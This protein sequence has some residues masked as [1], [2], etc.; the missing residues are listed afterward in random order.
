MYVCNTYM[1]VSKIFINTNF[2]LLRYLELRYIQEGTKYLDWDVK[3]E[4]YVELDFKLPAI[5]VPIENKNKEISA[6]QRVYLD[7]KTAGKPSKHH[8]KSKGV[9]KENVAVIYKGKPKSKKVVIAEGP[10][11]AATIIDVVD[12]IEENIPVLASL[13]LGNFATIGM[14]LESF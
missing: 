14:Y 10:E 5:I 7:P 1:H 8:K 13:S 2:L 12:A 6:I 11:T 9:L 3:T 4:N